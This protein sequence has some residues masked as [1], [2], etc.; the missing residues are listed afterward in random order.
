MGLDQNSDDEVAELRMRTPVY[1]T[2]DW[3]K[4]EPA[5]RIFHGIKLRA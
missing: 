1:F 3:A 4:P 2:R 5:Q